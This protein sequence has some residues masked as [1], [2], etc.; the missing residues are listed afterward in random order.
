MVLLM[1]LTLAGL[2]HESAVSWQVNWGQL[3]EDSFS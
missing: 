1:W 2:A 3:V